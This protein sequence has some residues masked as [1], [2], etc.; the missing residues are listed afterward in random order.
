[1]SDPWLFLL[2]T[3]AAYFVSWVIVE[4]AI[5]QPFVERLRWRFERRW[6]ARLES[7]HDDER[8]IQARMN[9]DIFNSKAAYLLSCI[10]CLGFWVSGAV[11]VLLSL[12]YGLDYPIVA[13]LA[14]SGIVGLIG[15]FDRN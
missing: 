6:L 7:K 5:A 10:P 14:M 15:R 8:E 11:T 1:M 13:W 9:S 12:A 4:S 2:G 3:F